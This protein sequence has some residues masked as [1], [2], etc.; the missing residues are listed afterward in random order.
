MGIDKTGGRIPT[1]FKLFLQKRIKNS[2][3]TDHLGIRIENSAEKTGGILLSN[4]FSNA[5]WRFGAD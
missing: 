4:A 2:R 3:G 1:I 5:G